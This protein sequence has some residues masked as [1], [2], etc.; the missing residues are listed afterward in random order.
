MFDAITYILKLYIGLAI[1]S[2]LTFRLRFWSECE[3]LMCLG[4]SLYQF[5][6]ILLVIL[7]VS[8]N[9]RA[10]D[11]FLVITVFLLIVG[12]DYLVARRK[13]EARFNFAKIKINQKIYDF[14]DGVVKFE[15]KSKS[16]RISIWHFVY[17][18]VFL[19]GLFLWVRP[20]VYNQS[21]FSIV[22]HSHLVKITSILTN[23]YRAGLSDFGMNSLCAFFSS[24][25]GVNQ[26][27]V[28]HLFGAFNF[29]LL[30][31]GISLLAYKLSKDF[32]SVVLSVSLF[33]FLF[34]IVN[35]VSNPVEGSSFLFGLAW[36]L[37]VVVFWSEVSLVQK[38]IGLGV[39][40]LIDVFVGF[41]SVVLI[42]MAEIVKK[43]YENFKANR[44]KGIQFALIAILILLSFF[45]LE[46]YF[47]VNPELGLKV[48]SFLSNSEVVAYPSGF[49][50][51]LIFLV[52]LALIVEFISKTG[53]G[54]ST[55]SVFYGIFIGLLLIFTLMIEK[56]FLNFAPF[57]L[58][59]PFVLVNSF[60]WISYIISRF[61]G[62]RRIY[63]SVVVLCIVA[64]LILNG[65]LHGG[66]KFNGSIEPEEIVEVVREIQ[67]ESV[68]FSFAV[69][70]HYGT[71]AMIENYAWF[72]DWD[73]F[74]KSYILINEP[75]KIYDVVYVI[76]PKQDSIGK[77]SPFFLPSVENLSAVLDSVCLNYRYATVQL[78][79]DGR[80]IKVYKL[81][82]LKE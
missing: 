26:Y 18:L 30:F 58:F 60:I 37:I 33:V 2:Y 54:R 12:V 69:V 11:V 79:F 10:F 34:P 70:S 3:G 7:F 24:I 6:S 59:Y 82:K 51:I 5:L 56:G 45:L 31:L 32:I 16:L 36:S 9:L 29:G 25:F 49:I 75:K 61:L 72:M 47:S 76:V 23:D 64:L 17:I 8:V 50:N 46:N 63:Y 14:V 22:Q 44:K 21:L 43:S 74:L 15:L 80:D 35:F 77:I 39:S 1:I 41:A 81:T 52:F 42:T 71:R 40:F 4:K 73:Y 65:F 48:Y 28:L 55:F 62:R 67:S 19:L 13:K 78:Y 66:F 20:S 57:E 68:P 53:E 27:M 38:F